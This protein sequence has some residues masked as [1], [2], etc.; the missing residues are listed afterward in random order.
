MS[1]GAPPRRVSAAAILEWG[2]IAQLPIEDE[3]MAE[4][5]AAGA[6]AAAEAVRTVQV[7]LPL[8]GPPPYEPADYLASLE[9]CAGPAD[10]DSR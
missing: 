3:V 10:E 6:A 4:R 9:R 5:I 1:A 8:D 2:L 7:A